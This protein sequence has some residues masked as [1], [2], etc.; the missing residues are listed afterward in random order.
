MDV[1]IQN[2]I[3]PSKTLLSPTPSSTILGWLIKEAENKISKTFRKQK[4][5]PQ[6]LK[7]FMYA[8]QPQLI[9]C[10]CHNFV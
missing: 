7:V 2:L 10:F 1:L 8:K 9:T 3:K 4:S 6:N 5:F